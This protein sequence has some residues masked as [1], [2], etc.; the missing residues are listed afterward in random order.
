M[1]TDRERRATFADKLE[2][3]INDSPKTQQKIAFELN[4]DNQNIITMFKKG[5]TRVPLAKV[6][7]FAQTL[8]TDPAALIRQWFETYMPE[9]L[10]VIEQ[11]M[12]MVLSGP[13]KTWV[14]GLRKTFPNGAPTFDT[15]LGA[16]IKE[17]LKDL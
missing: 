3:L 1:P 11:H 13:E 14:M 8:G 2:S 4:Y 5:T 6:V 9:A 12:G 10:T 15:R 16:P 7:P 17:A